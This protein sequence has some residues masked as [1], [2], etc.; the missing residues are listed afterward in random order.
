M[1]DKLHMIENNETQQL[2]GRPKNRKVIGV[3]CIL[4]TKINHDGKICKNKASLVVQGCAQQYG[5]DYQKTFS[6]DYQK[7]IS[8]IER[9]DT[10]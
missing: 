9:Y 10:I 8:P 4:K 6:P 3:R 7:K 5:A 1:K 2:G